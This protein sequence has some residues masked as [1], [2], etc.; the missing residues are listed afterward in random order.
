TRNRIALWGLQM[1]PGNPAW[2]LFVL[3]SSG[4][5][6]EGPISNIF[7]SPGGT[8]RPQSFQTIRIAVHRQTVWFATDAGLWRL[9]SSEAPGAREPQSTPTPPLLPSPNS[10]SARGGLR[11]EAS[12]DLPQGA[13]LEAQ[14]VTIDD[15][16]V[17]KAVGL[18]TAD[19]MRSS[20][21]KQADI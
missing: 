4:D 17:V 7:D 12:I 2:L 8:K 19:P 14:V 13:A 21:Q 18:I 11:A 3:D 9:D 1:A 20:E 6:V 16:N 10:D 5:T 15:E